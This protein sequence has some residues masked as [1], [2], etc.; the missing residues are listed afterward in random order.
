MNRAVYVKR[1]KE[2]RPKNPYSYKRLPEIIDLKKPITILCPIHNEFTVI[3]HVHLKGKSCPKCVK[4]ID[5]LHVSPQSFEN[6]KR[7]Y[8]EDLKPSVK[9]SNDLINNLKQMPAFQKQVQHFSHFFINEKERSELFQEYHENNPNVIETLLKTPK[10][11]TQKLKIVFTDKI[12]KLMK[13]N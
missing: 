9:I 7:F 1:M 6:T 12:M 13:I 5:D 4:S 3:A 2:L 8:I 11:E 10:N